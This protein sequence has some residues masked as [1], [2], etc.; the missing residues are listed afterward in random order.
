MDGPVALGDEHLD[1]P[2][3]LYERL[4]QLAGYTWDETKDP[5]HSSYDNW[6]VL[7]RCKDKMQMLTKG[8]A[9]LWLERRH[10]QVTNQAYTFETGLGEQLELEFSGSP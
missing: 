4:R 8:Q 6:Q 2:P 9:S 1:P 7:E 5:F 10:P 3:R